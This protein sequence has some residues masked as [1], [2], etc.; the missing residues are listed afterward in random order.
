MRG[1]ATQIKSVG[2]ACAL[3]CGI[4][5]ALP[6]TGGA[7]SNPPLPPP[8][9]PYQGAY[10]QPDHPRLASPKLLTSPPK[11]AGAT[12]ALPHHV[13]SGGTSGKGTPKVV[14]IG[15]P[16]PAPTPSPS[17][18]SIKAGLP[19]PG[20]T[21]AFGTTNSI[22]GS[23]ELNFNGLKIAPP[24]T[25]IAT[26]PNSNIEVVNDM[27]SFTQKSG[28]VQTFFDLNRF[29]AVPAGF[30][31]TDP[32]IV[33]DA[34]AGRWYMSGAA[35]DANFDSYVYLAASQN[36]DATGYWWVYTILDQHTS[37]TLCDQPHLGFSSDK[38]V[39]ACDN[40]LANH[41]PQS[42]YMVV[43][44]GGAISGTA[45][46]YIR[47]FDAT[48][49]AKHFSMQPVYSMTPTSTEYLVYNSGY[50]VGVLAVF[51]NPRS[52]N[53]GWGESLDPL[54]M[55]AMAS[56]P[57]AAQ[58]GSTTLLDTG[59]FR[60]L[61][62][63]FQ[64]N[65]I[66]ISSNDS[67]TPAGDTAKHSCMRLDRVDVTNFPHPALNLDYD[68]G[69]VGTDLF[70]PA[71]T[72]DQSGTVYLAFSSSSANIYPEFDI[73]VITP[74][75]P[76]AI[77]SVFQ[78]VAGQGSYSGPS[79]T[80]GGPARWG[81]YSGAAPDPNNPHGV[82]LAGEAAA[83][84]GQLQPNW[85]TQG[86]TFF[87][88]A[89]NSANLT[90]NGAN[91][92]YPGPLITLTAQTFGCWGQPQYRFWK[93]APGAGWS[94]VQ[95]YG[96]N[97]V[98][99]WDTSKE[100]V[101][102]TYKFE[103]DVRSHGFVTAYDQVAITTLT[104]ASS[105]CTA[106]KVTTNPASPAGTGAAVQITATPDP[107]F[108]QDPVFRF[109]IRPPGGAWTVVQ[110]YSQAA[111]YTWAST[112]APGSYGVEVDVKQRL[113]GSSVYGT[114]TN[115]SYSLA[116]CS[117]AGLS[118]SVSSPQTPGTAITL[119][120][121]ATCP[122]TASYRFW[123]RPPGGAWQVARDY[124][125]T[126]TFSWQTAGLSEGIYG[127]EVDVR[128]NGA[129]ASYEAV[130]SQ[131]FLLSSGPCAPGLTASPA[132]PGATGASLTFTGT[133]VRCANPRYRFWLQPPGASWS[134]VQ[135][136]GAGATFQWAGSSTPGIYHVEVDTRDASES[137]AY[138]GV[139]SI[140]FQVSAC[141]AA[142]LS[143]SPASPQLPGGTV[144]LTGSSTCPGTPVY[145][146]WLR[147]PGGT[148]QVTQDYS[149]TS[150]F[151]WATVGLPQGTYG[152]E[153]DVRNQG[154]TA[155]YE[156]TMNTPYILGQPCSKPTLTA[157]TG[158]SAPTGASVTLQASTTVCPHPL[159]RFWFRPPGGSWYT[160]GYN[161]PDSMGFAAYTFGP[162]NP[163]TAS[164]E[165][166]VKDASE[167]VDYDAVTNMTVEFI[168]CSNA[169][170]TA[171]FM[172]A[173]QGPVENFQASANCGGGQP[174]YRWWLKG[175]GGNW[176]IVQDYAPPPQAGNYMLELRNL[177]PGTYYVEVDIRNYG[178]TV[179][180]ETTA[181]ATYVQ[182]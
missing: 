81:D 155:S 58:K 11:T 61:S 87:V 142:S 66:W 82:I 18:S 120:G 123:V 68:V 5:I 49:Q 148:W 26:G 162:F 129:T 122:G 169:F 172:Q 136:Y 79:S 53:V 131:S 39:V 95:D 36:T 57:P 174:Q 104:L 93:Q 90:S 70:Y 17:N 8:N 78:I 76:D 29:F 40:F 114:P 38:I 75:T 15:A 73:A 110:D 160:Y 10:V 80:T 74:A 134:I 163:G 59:D 24:D 103:V 54:Y 105:L 140:A 28:G 97:S 164:F 168:P 166:D 176:Q 132:S 55:A 50:G 108:C 121:S 63:V 159:Y 101:L 3:A 167:T 35:F 180:Y 150:T 47:F 133:A 181:T 19:P 34:S 41:V 92:T 22:T 21:N 12:Q 135:E 128:D 25:Q 144:T 84:S 96:P 20:S 37:K 124:S 7:A 44:K 157:S 171:N 4:W 115:L 137:V 177:A 71:V 98:Y 16:Q 52:G 179:A 94:I 43:D 151:S 145:R 60:M 77:D 147:P 83:G 102:G 153:V 126:N 48:D 69:S 156:A 125:T 116:P 170:L 113:A 100:T 30:I 119:T 173:P 138:D 27:G 117:T 152:L 158:P 6:A 42:G 9:A 32:K 112:G 107:M 13:R 130:S 146:F 118:A 127:L 2:L 72:M 143:V 62:A 149:A 51:G 141:S 139:F 1:V 56:P 109:W 33:Y 165:V 45:Y 175:P 46:E 65:I 64:S 67:C 89:C 14:T 178:T 91:A 31:F 86:G 88:P 182:H 111:T 154:S 161:P 99:A 106:A 85:W 23:D